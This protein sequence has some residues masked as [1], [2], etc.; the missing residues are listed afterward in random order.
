MQG[1]VER[2]ALGG[3]LHR[4]AQPGMQGLVERRAL[5]RA[6]QPVG[7]ARCQRD[8]GGLPGDRG[9][10]LLQ[11]GEDGVVASSRVDAVGDRALPQGQRLQ[12]QARPGVPAGPVD[13]VTEAKQVQ[14]LR[15]DGEPVTAGRTDQPA[16]RIPHRQTGFDQP[17]QE[18]HV[19]VDRVHRG[20]R[21]VGA[22]HRVDDVREAHHLAAVRQEQG[23]QRTRLRGTEV[24]LLVTAPGTNRAQHGEPD[25]LMGHLHESDARCGR[26][27]LAYVV[28]LTQLA[29]F[30]F[31][32]FQIA[33]FQF[34]GGM[35][36]LIRNTF[37]GSKR[38]LISC[39]RG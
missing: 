10:L 27:G 38:H 39:R 18:A 17:A 22:P 20:V 29:G 11:H 5:H 37:L 24:D 13:Q 8:V 15:V 32:G 28:L 16:P 14:A 12:E 33:G 21:R 36:W 23:E 2:C 35:L 25:I 26:G 4:A 30:Q 31:A 19:A 6:A 34:A 9:Q 1:L 7:V 3:A